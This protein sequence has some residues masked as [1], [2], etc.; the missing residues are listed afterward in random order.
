MNDKLLSL[1]SLSKR[2]NVLVYGFDTVV[3][4]CLNNKNGIIIVTNDVALNTIKK[5][6]NKIKDVNI[7]YVN[8]SKEDIFACIN[9]YTGII[10]IKDTSLSL[11]IL[12]LLNK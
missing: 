4:E 5:L 8:Y 10:Y 12:K 3:N 11:E 1:I 2:A 9:K 7:V 6:N